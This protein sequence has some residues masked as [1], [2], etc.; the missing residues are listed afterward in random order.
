[1]Q[2]MRIIQFEGA[3]VNRDVDKDDKTINNISRSQTGYFKKFFKKTK[4]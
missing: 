2:D 3:L 1:M 4:T